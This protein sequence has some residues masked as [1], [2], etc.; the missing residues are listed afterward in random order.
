MSVLTSTAQV[1]SNVGSG[2]NGAV[3]SM[4]N[5][6]V[7][8]RL[9]ATG[10][11]TG[12]VAYWNGSVWTVVPGFTGTYAG[13]SIAMHGTDLIVG[14]DSI[15]VY[16]GTNWYTVQ[17]VGTGGAGI[18]G[19]YGFNTICVYPPNVLNG[20]NDYVYIG[21]KHTGWNGLIKLDP[22]NNYSTTQVGPNLVSYSI[23][24][25]EVFNNKMYITGNFPGFIQ[26]YTLT[27][28]NVPTT[29][30][31]SSIPGAK[32]YN[33]DIYF[34]GGLLGFNGVTSANFIK[35]NGTSFL[36]TGGSAGTLTSVMEKYSNNLYIVTALAPGMKIWNG[37]TLTNI[38]SPIGSTIN[39]LAVYNGEL[40]A[41]GNFTTPYSNIAKY[42]ANPTL[43]LTPSSTSVSCFGGNNGT[44]TCSVSGGLP[45]YSYTW[46]PGN[47]T[48]STVSGLTAGTYTVKVLDASTMVKTVTVI[49]GQPTAVSATQTQSNVLCNGGN[50]GIASVV[51]SG[52]TA[53]YTYS[54][55][56]TGGTLPT[57]SS[58]V[59][60]SYSCIIKDANNCSITKVF[61]ITQPTILSVS[62]TQTIETMPSSNDGV[63]S[64]TVSG[65]TPSYTYSW[66]P[67]GGNSQTA[68]GLTGGTYTCTIT[69]NNG[70]SITKSFTITTGI[71]TGINSYELSSVIS[72][73]PNPSNGQFSI[74]AGNATVD[75]INSIGQ[76]VSHSVVDG[77]SSITVDA[78]GMYII[79][80]VKDGK[81]FSSRLI[82]Q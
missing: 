30:T 68:S 28:S 59:Q 76:I 24:D 61:N 52:G 25:L 3:N 56:P 55:S 2:L 41:G 40:F 50:S 26:S 75:V 49:V 10:N 66:S 9:Y 20:F 31:A 54:W 47:Y 37:T 18:S 22:S 42:N 17:G 78:P 60:G 57:A 27:L 51:A 44:A 29:Y 65:G 11:F 62:S 34:S 58:L 43:V 45:G 39:C 72:I 63:A 23:L 15:Y 6:T 48:T 46:T 71:A 77:K 12:K 1:W 73:Y 82:N 81:V 8:N 7:S 4:V 74:D 21:T 35:N 13:V 70:C 14:S 36:T 16:N 32:S 33:G 5:D 69:D 64:V 38:P 19:G 79:K 53:G 80:V 67:S